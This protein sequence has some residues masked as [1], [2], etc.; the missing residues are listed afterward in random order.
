MA[1]MR[2]ARS[3][4][5][6]EPPHGFLYAIG[7]QADKK[8]LKLVERYDPDANTWEAVSSVITPPSSAAVAVQRN[9]IYIIGATEFNRIETAS[10]ERWQLVGYSM[11]I[12]NCMFQC[13]EI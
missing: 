9:F 12:H 8:S 1:A 7:G 6:L 10:V 2:N 13:N 5:A 4:F 11:I 3:L